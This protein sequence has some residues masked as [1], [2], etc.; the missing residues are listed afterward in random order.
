MMKLAGNDATKIF[1][2][3]QVGKNG[4]VT[5]R[6]GMT[7][8]VTNQDITVAFSQALANKQFG[9]GGFDQLFIPDWQKYLDPISTFLLKSR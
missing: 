2:G 9:P 5:Y 4:F 3:L 6:Q 1:Q 7:Q 8:Y